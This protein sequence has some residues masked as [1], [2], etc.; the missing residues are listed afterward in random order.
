[1]SKYGY[2]A[3]TF[4]MHGSRKKELL[5]LGDLQAGPTH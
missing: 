2:I 4:S 1:M 3:C 5:P